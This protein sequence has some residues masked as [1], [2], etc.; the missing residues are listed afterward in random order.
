MNADERMHDTTMPIKLS[1]IIDQ[2]E[3]R[4]KLFFLT[5]RNLPTRGMGVALKGG[6]A[7]KIETACSGETAKDG[8]NETKSRRKGKPRA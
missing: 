5:Q 2:F 4:R 3:I 8:E 7:A 1:I 6:K